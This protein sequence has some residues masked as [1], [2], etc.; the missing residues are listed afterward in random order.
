MADVFWKKGDVDWSDILNWKTAT[1]GA[2]TVPVSTNGV[3]FCEGA[4]A[5]VDGLAQSAVDLA[6]LDFTDGTRVQV[7]GPGTSLVISC[8]GTVT[9]RAGGGFL[10][11]TAGSANITSMVIDAPNAQC[12]LTGGT[13]DTRLD[14]KSY[15]RINSSVTLSGVTVELHAGADVLISYKSDATDPTVI[16][17]AGSSL[18]LERPA[19]A[20]TNNGGQAVVD[21]EEETVAVA[22]LN[23]NNGVTKIL[24]G[25][26]T[27][28]NGY[29]GTVDCTGRTG[30]VTITN[31]TIGPNTKLIGMAGVTFSNPL[32][33]RGGAAASYSPAPGG[34]D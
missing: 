4:D 26:V 25:T 11:L 19:L 32:T 33:L 24:R 23:A 2:G 20:I 10:F 13:F 29:D 5:I 22:T 28:L 30:P 3:Y 15:C 31:G 6:S 18:L 1:G 16:V 14:I 9:Y 12:Y 34:S 17:N 27:Q 8:S 7:G 21:V